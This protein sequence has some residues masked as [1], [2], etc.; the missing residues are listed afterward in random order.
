MPTVDGTGIAG[1]HDSS[2]LRPPCRRPN[3]VEAVP[4]VLQWFYQPTPDAPRAKPEKSFMQ[5]LKDYD[6]AYL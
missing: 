6:V 4:R 2:E 1:Q 5:K 3:L